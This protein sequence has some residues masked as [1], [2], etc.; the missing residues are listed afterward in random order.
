MC[1]PRYALISAIGSL[2]YLMLGSRLDLAF[3]INNWLNMQAIQRSSTGFAPGA[4]CSS[5]WASLS[6]L[7]LVYLISPFAF[8]FACSLH[9]ILHCSIFSF[10]FPL[11]SPFAFAFLC[12]FLLYHFVFFCPH[13]NKMIY[14]RFYV[15]I[16]CFFPHI[17]CGCRC[18]AEELHIFLY[19]FYLC[20]HIF[21]C[22][23]LRFFLYS[24]PLLSL[25]I[26][27]PVTMLCPIN[28]EIIKF[29]CPMEGY[30]SISRRII[31][32]ECVVFIKLLPC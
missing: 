23:S 17:K 6:L 32:C 24:P 31:L 7:S 30:C 11:A 29:H 18:R 13:L 2:I 21:P 25:C 15:F 3:S 16:F 22:F 19:L 10:S 8:S 27:N 4:M 14:Y 1:V 12:L 28:I 9:I 26:C 20:F 5:V